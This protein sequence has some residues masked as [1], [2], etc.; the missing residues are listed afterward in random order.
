MYRAAA[1]TR[2][3]L[4]LDSHV[5]RSCYLPDLLGSRLGNGHLALPCQEAIDGRQYVSETRFHIGYERDISRIVAAE[6]GRCLG[7]RYALP[8]A[9]RE[10][11]ELHHG[12]HPQN[13]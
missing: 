7:E 3:N 10:R 8:R 5:L 12:L 9:V 4:F 2:E 11:R 1:E 6:G 13:Q